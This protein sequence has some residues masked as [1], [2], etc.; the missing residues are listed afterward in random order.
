MLAQRVQRVC[1]AFRRALAHPLPGTWGKINIDVGNA[2]EVLN[3]DGSPGRAF[4]LMLVLASWFGARQAGPPPPPPFPG[5]Q[6][7]SLVNKV[8]AAFLSGVGYCLP[9]RSCK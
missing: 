6:N 4:N 5:A 7:A 1:L 2:P 8:C 9:R 3:P